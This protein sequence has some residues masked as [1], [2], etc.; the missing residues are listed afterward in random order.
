MET[1]INVPQLIETIKTTISKVVPRGTVI[2]VKEKQNYFGGGKYLMIFF[3]PESKTIHG[4]QG[5][6]PQVVS[7]CLNFDDMELKPQ[8][9]GG[10]GGQ[11]IYREPDRNHP[12]EKYLAMA[13]IK[14]PFRKPK[15]ELKFIIPAI[16]RFASNWVVLLKENKDKLKYQDYVNYNEFLNS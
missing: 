11:C 14:I 13:S 6:Y 15:P 12:R 5:Q 9:Y 3:Y 7:L 8:V 1:N 10:N 2:E 16:E 4:V